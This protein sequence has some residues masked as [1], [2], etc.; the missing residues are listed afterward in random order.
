[1]TE[2]STAGPITAF[3]AL[4]GGVISRAQA[5]SAGASLGLIR[6][7]LQRSVW[8]KLQRGSYAT[9]SGP[10]PRTAIIWAALLAAGDGA[11]L[12]HYMAAEVAGLL[13]TP[14][15]LIHLTVPSRRRVAPIDG[16]VV[17]ICAHA[18]DR[19]HPTRVPAQTRIE[20]TV[21]DLADLST[22]ADDAIGWLSSACG[23]RLTTP[24]RLADALAARSRA[25]WRTSL[26]AALSHVADGAHSLLEY[27]YREDVEIAHGLPGGERPV[28]R[29]TDGGV[30]YE[31]VHYDVGVSVEL[32]EWV[33]HPEQ[34]RLRDLQRDNVAASRGDVVLHFG[35]TDVTTAPCRVALQVENALRQ[36]GWRNTIGSCGPN[37]AVRSL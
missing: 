37:C 25:R 35:W 2:S 6:S 4:Q 26:G 32:D 24:I 11:M 15:R 9:F 10:L 23:R 14:R 17:H 28:R 36:R 21:L 13:D 19:R 34:N 33:A 22:T 31:D 1:M 30:I 20:E 29:E 3:A 5:L 8:Q 27:R 7:N 12:S 18:D 16:A